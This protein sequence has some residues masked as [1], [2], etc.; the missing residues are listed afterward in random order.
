MNGGEQREFVEGAGVVREVED[1][2]GVRRFA[3]GGAGGFGRFV[4]HRIAIA[5]GEE[6]ETGRQGRQAP[7]PSNIVS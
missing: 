2:E 6:Q 5:S 4:L 1:A 3:E 7:R